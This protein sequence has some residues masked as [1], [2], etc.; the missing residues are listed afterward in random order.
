MNIIAVGIAHG[1]QIGGGID[2]DDGRVLRPVA[3]DG[4]AAGG[5]QPGESAEGGEASHAV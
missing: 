2:L 1:E 5:Q 3:D 4:R